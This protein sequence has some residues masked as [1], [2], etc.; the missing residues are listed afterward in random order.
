MTDSEF[1]PAA[2]SAVDHCWIAPDGTFWPVAFAN[3]SYFADWKMQ[4]LGYDRTWV[5]DLEKLGWLHFS[6]LSLR[7]ERPKFTQRQFDT[8]WDWYVAQKTAGRMAEANRLFDYLDT[9]TS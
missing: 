9:Q 7:N 1:A 3:H 5:E 2:P 4:E 8:I 6:D